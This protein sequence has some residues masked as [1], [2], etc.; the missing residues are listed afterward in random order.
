MWYYEL[1][2]QPAGPVDEAE[3]SR[4]LQN[5]TITAL[6]LVWRDGM[7]DWK[8]LGETELSSLARS[9]AAPVQP[10][11]SVGSANPYANPVAPS[12]PT[13]PQ[14]GAA[15]V[16]SGP[17]VSSSSLK[18]LFNI[19]VVLMLLTGVYE[20][21]TLMIPTNTALA[22]LSCIGS[23]VSLGAG[24]LG[25]IL[26]YKFW[27]VNQDGHASTTP[28]KAVGFMFIPIF[29]IYWLFRAFPG[30][31]L[32]QN[33]YIAD[34]FSGQPEGTVKKANPVIAFAYI[35]FSFIGGV[36]LAIIS[37]SKAVSMA[38]ASMDTL[39]PTALAGQFTAPIGIFSVVMMLF[40]IWMYY[41]FYSTA[42][43]IC[44]AEEQGA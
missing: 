13:Y 2:H 25:L 21:I 4:L 26:L 17:R 41:G 6:T 20:I 12:A 34:H 14:Y 30:L 31:S 32:D 16:K 3:I 8:H 39:N 19:W 10:T 23:M 15:P 29:N 24:V 27:Q 5:G 40:Y 42:K 44:E 28:G 11:P 22:A 38:S 36:V 7:P 35:I 9:V 37:A 33:R 43:S 18:S 1:N